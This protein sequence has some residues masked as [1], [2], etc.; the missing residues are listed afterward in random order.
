MAIADFAPADRSVR[1]PFARGL[2][3]IKGWIAARR[4]ARARNSALESLL[5][6]PEHRLRDIGISREELIRAIDAQR[7]SRTSFWR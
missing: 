1:L 5:Y 3:A 6:A 7:E 4:I 2:A